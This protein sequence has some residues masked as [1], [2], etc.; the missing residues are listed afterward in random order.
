MIT[1]D[2]ISSDVVTSSALADVV[3]HHCRGFC[4]CPLP[5]VQNASQR[6]LSPGRCLREEVRARASS[7][8]RETRHAESR[9]ECDTCADRVACRGCS[10]PTRHATKAS[11]ACVADYGTRPAFRL[12][13]RHRVDR[14]RF[15]QVDRTRGADRPV[16]SRRRSVP[17][18][19]STLDLANEHPQHRV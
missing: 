5:F 11:R 16:S 15:R 2:H 6:A 4:D 18:A 7:R 10:S 9:A 3:H 13:D 1:Y 19:G 14:V 8:S 17:E 12:L